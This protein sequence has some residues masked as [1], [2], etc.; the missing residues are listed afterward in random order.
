MMMF[1]VIVIILPDFINFE[2]LFSTT[3]RFACV[4]LTDFVVNQMHL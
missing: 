2:V 3:I 1:I 4:V